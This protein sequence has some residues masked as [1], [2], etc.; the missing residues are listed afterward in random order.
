MQ[1]LAFIHSFQ[2]SP[3][4]GNFQY[5]LK[6]PLAYM[7]GLIDKCTADELCPFNKEDV[8]GTNQ[9]F[10]LCASRT[11]AGLVLR[12]VDRLWDGPYLRHRS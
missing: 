2:P 8:P 5:Y 4:V 10:T 3:H 9:M 12:F 7:I 11:C 6:T 1:F